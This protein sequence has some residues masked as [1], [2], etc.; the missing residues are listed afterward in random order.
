MAYSGDKRSMSVREMQADLNASLAIGSP[1]GPMAYAL[2]HA[3]LEYLGV[4][5]LGTF[6]VR[7]RREYILLTLHL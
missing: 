7:R 5:E 4:R 2:V 3:T 6:L 1:V